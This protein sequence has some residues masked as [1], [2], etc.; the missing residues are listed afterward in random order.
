MY[1]VQVCGWVLVCM[2]V[3]LSLSCLEL[4][5][6]QEVKQLR[7]LLPH[8]NG[9]NNI[10]CDQVS[11]AI[12]RARRLG[13]I[14]LSHSDMFTLLSLAWNAPGGSGVKPL[15][16]PSIFVSLFPL[17]VCCSLCLSSFWDFCLSV[18]ISCGLRHSLFALILFH[19]YL[20][21][22]LIFFSCCGYCYSFL[23][24]SYSH[25]YFIF[26]L[27][28]AF[29]FVFN[30]ALLFLPFM[31]IFLSFFIF[32]FPPYLSLVQILRLGDGLQSLT[33]ERVY[34]VVWMKSAVG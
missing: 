4:L 20:L 14:L 32:L 16:F 6:D 1:A 18:C 15:S 10:H 30:F 5:R 33:L 3:C 19:F 17:D 26:S 23:S 25:S 12:Y 13:R 8:R 2:C 27:L 34:L 31:S 28:T 11:V 21:L 9:E 24:L 7:K 22:F 29:L